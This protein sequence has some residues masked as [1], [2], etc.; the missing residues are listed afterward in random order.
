M[1]EASADWG[2]QI[3][4]SS[5]AISPVSPAPVRVEGSAEENVILEKHVL[6]DF[7]ETPEGLEAKRAHGAK[8]TLI[9]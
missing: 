5:G 2:K 3:T 6:A 8:V 7:G 1:G 4:T 9:L